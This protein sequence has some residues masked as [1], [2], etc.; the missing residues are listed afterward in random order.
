MTDT[1][2]TILRKMTEL[3]RQQNTLLCQ[4]GLFHVWNKVGKDMKIVVS[5]PRAR[6]NGGNGPTSAN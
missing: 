5:Q 3:Q 1:P 4:P 2:E 6:K